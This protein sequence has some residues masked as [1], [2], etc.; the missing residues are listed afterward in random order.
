LTLINASAPQDLKPLSLQLTSCL[1]ALAL[2]AWGARGAPRALEALHAPLPSPQITHSSSLLLNLYALTA[3]WAALSLV[4]SQLIDPS[5]LTHALTLTLTAAIGR[6]GL[7]PH[8]DPTS[9]SLRGALSALTLALLTLLSLHTRGGTPLLNPLTL[10]QLTAL[11][12]LAWAWRAQDLSP[13]TLRLT[14]L[15]GFLSL[16]ALLMRELSH[17]GVARFAPS[18]FFEQPA[19][20]GATSVL[21]ATLALWLM[22]YGSVRGSAEGWRA[23]LALMGLTLAKLMWVDLSLSGGLG[24]MFGFMGAGAV[25]LL[26]GYWAPHPSARNEETR[27]AQE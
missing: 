3:L 27:K 9:P 26:V 11:S 23:G 10:T 24:V 12:A 6:V 20:Q 22:R 25:M 13:L 2:C 4:A 17:L 8:S 5:W 15:V 7:I 19:L 21:W 18:A 14:G 16:N 1:A